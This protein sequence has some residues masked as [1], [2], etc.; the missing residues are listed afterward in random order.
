MKR[1]IRLK[2][3]LLSV[4][5][6]HTPPE[7]YRKLR[8]KLCFR[9]YYEETCEQGTIKTEL[10]ILSENKIIFFGGSFVENLYADSKSRITSVFEKELNQIGYDVQ[11]INAGVSGAT[12]LN[13]FNLFL[14]KFLIYKPKEI[15]FFIPTNDG[16]CLDLKGGL[17]NKMQ[18][19][20]NLYNI[21][22]LSEWD[23]LNHQLKIEEICNIY[24]LLIDACRLF[25][26][27][28]NICVSPVI[29]N[30]SDFYLVQEDRQA[31]LYKNRMKVINSVVEHC[32]NKNI[33]VIDLR[34]TF[35]NLK[36]MF[37]DDVHLNSLGSEK[38][39]K[40]LISKMR[41]DK[42]FL[43]YLTKNDYYRYEIIHVKDNVMLDGE[44]YW[45]EYIFLDEKSKYNAILSFDIVCGEGVLAKNALFCVDFGGNN[46]ALNECGLSLS[47]IV[48]NYQYLLTKE[49]ID[50][51]IHHAF[52]I[53]IGNTKIRIGFR[54]WDS[55]KQI[56]LHNINLYL[57]KEN[58]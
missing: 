9:D 15:F 25:N 43:R 51:N 26:I 52:T 20:S 2:E 12:T 40:Y 35:S 6:I 22:F 7:E 28:L 33:Q 16:Y 58:L 36:D 13:L 29:K 48:G 54:L 8:P 55:D 31:S 50:C 1:Y 32:K 19:Y 30:I 56:S 3:R 37:V 57:R 18:S 17:W 27:K 39:G 47:P 46:Y 34:D 11:I 45:S 10:S 4:K 42:N 49:L 53:P 23:T 44:I 24:T 38:I 5:R 41:E 21:N 14:N